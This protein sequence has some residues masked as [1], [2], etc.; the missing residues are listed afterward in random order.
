MGRGLMSSAI[1][2]AKYFKK[3]WVCEH[4]G[5]GFIT[6]TTERDAG[7]KLKLVIRLHRKKCRKV[8]NFDFDAIVND[9]EQTANNDSSGMRC[10]FTKNVR[11]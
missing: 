9:F 4:C 8:E 6:T 10:L 7:T 5:K 11:I 1:Q 3:T 2:S